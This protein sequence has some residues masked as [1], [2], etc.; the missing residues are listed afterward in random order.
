MKKKV[1]EFRKNLLKRLESLPE[2][3]DRKPLIEVKFDRIRKLCESVNEQNTSDIISAQHRA[4]LFLILDDLEELSQEIVKLQDILAEEE[5]QELE[6]S[7]KRIAYLIETIAFYTRHR[8]FAEEEL[9]NGGFR[10]A[11]L[12]TKDKIPSKTYEKRASTL[13]KKL[14]RIRRRMKNWSAW[15]DRCTDEETRRHLIRQYNIF[16]EHVLTLELSIDEFEDREAEQQQRLK[17]HFEQE[18]MLFDEAITMKF[19]ESALTPWF[20]WIRKYRFLR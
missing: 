18:R 4:H 15:I 13:R 10:N 1:K 7:L 9:V 12:M 3:F 8:H 2:I 14:E 16:Q 20:S 17:Q 6:E 19:K 11:I 5:E